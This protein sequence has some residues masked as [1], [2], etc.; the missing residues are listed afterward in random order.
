MILTKIPVKKKNDV[1]LVITD[2]FREDG[3]VKRRSVKSLG[4]L[5]KLKEQYDDPIAYFTEVARQMTE[6]KKLTGGIRTIKIDFSNK[7]TSENCLF[8]CG[9]MFIKKAFDSLKLDYIFR[10]YKDKS[11]IKANLA[12]IFEFLTINQII[13]PSSKLSSFYKKDMYL[14][15]YNFDLDEIYRSLS[16]INKIDKE[17]QSQIYKNSFNLCERDASKLYYDCT[18]YYFEIEVEDEF[19]KFGFSKEHRPNPIVQMG[20]FIDGSGIPVGYDLFSGNKNEQL[21]MIPIEK[22]IL[23]TYK[24]SKVVVCADAGLCSGNNKIFNSFADKNYIFVQSLKKAKSYINDEIFDENN[25]KW[26]KINENLKYY[27]RNINDKVSTTLF[28]NGTMMVNHE[29]KLIITFDQDFC[30]YMKMVRQKR[31]EK[32]LKIIENPNSFTKE[33]S[34]DGKQYIKTINYDGNGEIIEKKLELDFEKIHE[35]EK[36]DGYYALITSLVDENPMN[37]IGINKQR[38]SIEDCFRT[39]KTDLKARPVFLSSEDRIRT[40]FLIAYTSLVLLKLIQKLLKKTISEEDSTMPK[41]LYALRNFSIVK[42]ENSIYKNCGTNEIIQELC[43][44]FNVKLDNDF[45]KGD[46][47]KSFLK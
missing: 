16:Y 17:I 6:E 4:Y 27:S 30:D 41:I 9:S 47:L 7:S 38:W 14:K 1:Y 8:N 15:K 13:D 18:N 29:A 24:T 36:Y 37:I 44:I 35:E 31:I 28:S 10:K 39:L 32:A 3:K 45:I 22:E 19:R 21:S 43:K 33:T 26:V 23:K 25:D 34:K 12:G 11:K 2:A 20:M 5:S 42:I 46:Y 40:H